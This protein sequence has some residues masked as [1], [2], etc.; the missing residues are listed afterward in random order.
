MSMQR[1][2]EKNV[3]VTTLINGM[4]NLDLEELDPNIGN[5]YFQI[6]HLNSIFSTAEGFKVIFDRE[7]PIE[8]R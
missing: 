2:D 1:F 5:L 4:E 7:I 6:I 8:L 3:D